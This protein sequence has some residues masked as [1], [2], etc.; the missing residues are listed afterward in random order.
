MQ[1]LSVKVNRPIRVIRNTG[2]RKVNQWATIK[3]ATS[4]EVLHVGQP[5]YIERIA[6]KRYNHTVK[7]S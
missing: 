7:V 3:C 4:G 2:N 6:R 5:K 1:S